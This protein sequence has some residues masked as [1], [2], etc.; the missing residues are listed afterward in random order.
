MSYVAAAPTE[1][2]S[3]SADIIAAITAR[4]GTETNAGDETATVPLTI[5]EENQVT[6]TPIPTTPSSP[7]ESSY[8]VQSEAPMPLGIDMTQ[9]V[10]VPAVSYEWTTYC[11]DVSETWDYDRSDGI[12]DGAQ[13]IDFRWL[14]A[15]SNG[16]FDATDIATPVWTAPRSYDNDGPGP[17]D[18]YGNLDCLLTV[19]VTFDDGSQSV[20]EIRPMVYPEEFDPSMPTDANFLYPS[21]LPIALSGW[22][23][24][25]TTFYGVF[26]TDPG[27]PV[28]Y[29][30][31][32][33]APSEPS[34]DY[35]FN[36]YSF[37]FWDFP[38]PTAAANE[39]FVMANGSAPHFVIAEVTPNTTF[40]Q[41]TMRFDYDC[42]G[43]QAF[44]FPDDLDTFVFSSAP[45]PRPKLTLAMV[46][47]NPSN[48]VELLPENN[49]EAMWLGALGNSGAG[50][51]LE[52]VLSHQ[53]VSPRDPLP[54][55]LELCL[56]EAGDAFCGVEELT[57]DPIIITMG[58]DDPDTPLQDSVFFARL[59]VTADPGATISQNASVNRLFLVARDP[60]TKQIYGATS[61]D[62]TT[63]DIP[64]GLGSN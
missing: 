24:D 17:E 31:C 25:T 1:P 26:V 6:V 3:V 60:V 38:V 56:W 11:P 37:S 61:F 21:T 43:T 7:G 22:V 27:D 5:Y 20:G 33:M 42:N 54:V 59:R 52:V 44:D 35:E 62:V 34:S 51:E 57:E 12:E 58:A 18:T 30:N 16:S 23:G 53:M 19:T 50:G 28:N 2:P 41:F 29:V 40:E 10:D 36:F 64:G 46:P 14:V 4:D 63:N 48:T 13:F 47:P 32:T 55:T 8:W 49:G 15:E 9:L 45:D 39:P